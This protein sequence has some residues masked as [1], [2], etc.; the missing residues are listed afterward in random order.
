MTNIVS[1]GR[2]EWKFK[3]HKLSGGGSVGIWNMKYDPKPILL[4]GIAEEAERAYA[5]L[6]NGARLNVHDKAH[7]WTEYESYGQVCQS[8]GTISMLVDFN[9][10]TMSFEI[11]GKNYGKA[12]DIS[13]GEYCAVMTTNDPNVKIELLSYETA[14]YLS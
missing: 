3:I 1:K 2:H 13:K 5:F 12:F 7:E 4:K 14:L 6:L 9:K 11:N 8:G 10:L